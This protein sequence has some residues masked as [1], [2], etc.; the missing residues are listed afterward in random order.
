MEMSQ[1]DFIKAFDLL[2]KANRMGVEKA[3]AQ[4]KNVFDYY[5]RRAQEGYPRELVI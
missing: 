2:E 5:K 3:K 1:K 4:I